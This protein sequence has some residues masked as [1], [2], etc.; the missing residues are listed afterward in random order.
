MVYTQFTHDLSNNDYVSLFGV[1]GMTELN[2]NTFKVSQ[3]TTN[4]FALHDYDA[5]SLDSDA[6]GSGG[7]VRKIEL[8]Y[9]RGSH[10]H[11][12]SVIHLPEANIFPITVTV[13]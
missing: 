9:T 3:A 12:R 4:S 7:I 5:T 10:T 11:V 6:D 2:G 13:S 1:G 8:K